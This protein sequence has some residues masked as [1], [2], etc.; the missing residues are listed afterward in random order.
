MAKTELI[1][2]EFGAIKLHRNRLTRRLKLRINPGGAISIIMPMRTPLFFVKGFLNDS[3]DFVRKNLNKAGSA[4]AILR[5]GDIIG[6]THRLII[7]HSDFWHAKIKGTEL[8][9]E[10]PFGSAIED[11]PSQDFIKKEALKA[12]RVQA[13]SYL[14]RR[15]DYLAQ[16]HSFSYAKLRYTTAG[17]RW[18]SCSSSGTISLNVWLM[19]LPHELI[20]Y[21]LIHEL[22]HTRELNHSPAFWQ[23][24]AAIEPSFKDLRRALK[25]QHPFL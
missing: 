6:K 7:G 21:V 10:L 22:C 4:K 3:R 8:M 12:L 16:T 9:V 17:T 19:Q 2:P 18:G 5:H 13:K 25:Q 24:V 1:D 23:H 20:D 15:L 14:S 11:P